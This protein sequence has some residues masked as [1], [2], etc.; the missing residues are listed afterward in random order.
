MDGRERVSLSR[1]SDPPIDRFV[2]STEKD[3]AYR[4][5]LRNTPKVPFFMRFVFFDLFAVSGVW[6]RD[7]GKERS[8]FMV[9]CL[10]RQPAYT[11]SYLFLSWPIFRCPLWAWGVGI[12]LRVG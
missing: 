7:G 9:I 2:W 1:T 5:S 6:L 10:A 8:I 12:S 11:H 4:V 3:K